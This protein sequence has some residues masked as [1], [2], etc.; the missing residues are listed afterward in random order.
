MRL[1]LGADHA[2]YEMKKGLISWLKSAAG[3]RHQV[4]DIGTYSPEPCDYPDIAEKVSRMVAGGRAARGILLCGTGTGMAIVAN[5]I[6][7]VRSG[8][9]WIPA[10]AELAAEHNHV[11]V[12]CIPSRFTTLQKAEK[13]IQAFLKTKFAGGRHARRVN[14]IDV[15]DQRIRSR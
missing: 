8:V 14:K 3:G 7:G 13:M 11:N 10:A 2:G 4:R 15:L 1:I 5:K 12:L 9:A 6:K